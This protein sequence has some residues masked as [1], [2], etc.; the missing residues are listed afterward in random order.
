MNHDIKTKRYWERVWDGSKILLF[1]VGILLG[2]LLAVC[3]VGILIYYLG[4]LIARFVPYWISLIFFVTICLIEVC[5]KLGR[6]LG[7]E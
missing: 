2:C 3:I 1:L 6:G 7:E 5:H 4:S